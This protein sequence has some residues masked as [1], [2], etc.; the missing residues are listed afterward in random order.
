MASEVLSIPEES[1]AEV[2]RVLRAGML[3]AKNISTATRNSLKQW[4][5]EEEE[6]LKRLA[7]GD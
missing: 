5:R 6:Y 2:I 4:C 7:D 1:L 3:S